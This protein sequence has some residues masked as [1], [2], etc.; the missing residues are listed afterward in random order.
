MRL[1][2]TVFGLGVLAAGIAAAASTYDVKLYDS[3]WVGSTELKKGDYKVEMKGDK[4]VFMSGKNAI[5]VP[6]TVSKSD[7]KFGY[8]SFVTEGTKLVEL[9]LGGTTDK[10]VFTQSAQGAAGSK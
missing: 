4:A 2:T 3:V 8:N 7:K 5:E 10:I 9:D 6:A 1:M